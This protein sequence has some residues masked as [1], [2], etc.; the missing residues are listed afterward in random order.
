MCIFLFLITQH[1]TSIV[2]IWFPV[3]FS[4]FSPFFS[5]NLLVKAKLPGVSLCN[6]ANC[7]FFFNL[8]FWFQS[9]CDQNWIL[10]DL[11]DERILDYGLKKEKV[12][13][14]GRNCIVS[15]SQSSFSP[16]SVHFFFLYSFLTIIFP[17]RI[18]Y[19]SEMAID[20]V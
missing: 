13:Q 14:L 10:F 3:Y 18:S 12:G 16:V 6:F 2:T 20:V 19:L 17:T 7:I 5:F 15:F 1:G 8:F 9:P 11:I 4:L